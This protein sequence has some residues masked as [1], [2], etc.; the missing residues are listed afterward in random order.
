MPQI[1]VYSGD[2]CPY[3][4]RAKALLDRKGVEYTEHN[5]GR[6]AEKRMALSEKSGG[7]KTIPQIFIDGKHIGGFDD[8]SALDDK[9][10]LDGL[11][12]L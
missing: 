9:G 4:T 11:L 3:C 7:A 6:D 1:D 2:Y 10:E 8:M 5:V 12:G